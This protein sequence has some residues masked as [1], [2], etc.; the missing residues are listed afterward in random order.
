MK[1]WRCLSLAS[2]AAAITGSA[3]AGEIHIAYPTVDGV[4]LDWCSNGAQSCGWPS[5]HDFCRVRGFER[6]LHFEVFDSGRTY[7]AAGDRF[8]A[9]PSCTA[10]KS[11]ICKT[12]AS[13]AAPLAP[14]TA[15]GTTQV[16]FDY[17]RND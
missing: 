6:A 15:L 13:E 4:P 9:G 12:A 5:A 10:F 11:V 17:P 3:V 1:I 8:C 14:P 7:I 16:R 2:I